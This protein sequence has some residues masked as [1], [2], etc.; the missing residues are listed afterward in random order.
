[1]AQFYDDFSGE[2]LGT[3]PGS[4]LSEYTTPIIFSVVEGNLLGT[5]TK[6]VLLDTSDPNVNFARQGA[7]YKK[8]DITS[9]GKTTVLLLCEYHEG[10]FFG[11]IVCGGFAT[12]R[13]GY[14][15]IVR[16]N[17]HRIFRYDGTGGNTTLASGGGPSSSLSDIN[18]IFTLWLEIIKDGSVIETRWWDFNSGTRPSVAQ[19]SVTDSTPLAEGW[20]GVSIL[21]NTNPDKM[22]LHSIRVGT[23]GDP[24]PTS[25]VATG[26]N[27]PVNPS[28]TNLLATS[29]RLNWEQG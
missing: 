26:P 20:V 3:S 7:S 23:D 14:A 24:A 16:F 18:D 2:P 8:S 25:P 12:D 10:N 17:D 11:S 9:S 6:K 28:V 15:Q 19:L 27:T 5:S 1:M 4:L 22:W 21:T 13:R 29:A